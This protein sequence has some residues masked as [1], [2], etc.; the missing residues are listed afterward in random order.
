MCPQ[1]TVTD[2]PGPAHRRRWWILA[3]IVLPVLALI[4]VVVTLS[5]GASLQRW[6]EGSTHGPWRSV[7]NG[8]GYT[9]NRGDI[10]VLEPRRSLRPDETHA[11]LVVSDATY[12][13]VD[14]RLQARTTDQLRKPE[15][16]AW[17]VAWVVWHYSDPLHF[18]Y[19]A[20]KPTGWELGKEDPAYPGAQRFLATGFPV[21]PIGRWHRVEIHQTGPAMTVEVDDQPV[22]TF[23]D[24]ERPYLSGS[25]GLYTEDAHVEFRNLQLP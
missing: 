7:F 19:L 17:E 18:Y 23:T 20:L 22:V 13:Q 3:A 25:V 8:E 9:G 6:P 1:R 14:F 4:L 11:A 10:L 12:Q 15:P 5:P 21:Y 24:Q 16:N 2:S